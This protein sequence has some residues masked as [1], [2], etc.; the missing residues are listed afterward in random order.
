MLHHVS[1]EIHPDHV[2]DCVG[3]WQIL[4]FTRLEAPP[5]IAKYV[6]WLER[7]TTQIHLIHTEEPTIPALGHPAV[8][9]D[10][11]EA[12]ISALEAAGIPFEHHRELWGKPRG[13]VIIP[14]GHR[15]E[16][17]AAPPPPGSA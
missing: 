11:Y 8:A 4:G 1:L 7:Q 9:V 13:F 5:E 6:S 3:A 12:T 16:M 14:G 2:E 15:V 10:D 17:M